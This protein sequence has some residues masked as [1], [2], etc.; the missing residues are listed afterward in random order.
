LFLA[1]EVAVFLVIA[2]EGNL[3]GFQ[4]TDFC[5]LAKYPSFSL[6]AENKILS[7]LSED[8]QMSLLIT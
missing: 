1:T 3:P 7:N 6:K 5:S 2:M 8:Y 4:R